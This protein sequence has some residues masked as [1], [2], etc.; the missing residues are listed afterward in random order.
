LHDR[1]HWQ[2]IWERFRSFIKDLGIKKMG[3]VGVLRDQ[4]LKE[5]QFQSQLQDEEKINC[6]YDDNQLAEEGCRHNFQNIV[7]IKYS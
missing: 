1:E 7:H 2:G 6:R 3:V 4:Y 5:V